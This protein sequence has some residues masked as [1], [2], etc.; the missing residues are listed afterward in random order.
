MEHQ[1]NLLLQPHSQ[2][3]LQ[4]GPGNEAYKGKAENEGALLSLHV[5]LHT[6]D[7]VMC[8]ELDQRRF[9]PIP[10]LPLLA[11]WKVTERSGED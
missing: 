4:N 6:C 1:G 10:R 8:S 2:A 5:S 9:S 7:G 11:E 3:L